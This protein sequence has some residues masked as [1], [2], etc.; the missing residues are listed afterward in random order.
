MR[1]FHLAR[2]I[3]GLLGSSY[4]PALR[5]T[6]SFVI[7]AMDA[8]MAGEYV[9]EIV[10]QPDG[11][12]LLAGKF[13]SVLGAKRSNIARLNAD[14]SLDQGFDPNVDGVV[15]SLLVL[16]D[17]QILLGG[18]FKSLQ[19]NGTTKSVPRRNIAKLQAD[20]TVDEKFTLRADSI[21]STMAQQKD[22]KIMLGGYF[23]S[24]QSSGSEVEVPQENLARV[25]VVGNID[26]TFKLNADLMM[27]SIIV[28]RDGSILLGGALGSL[29]SSG[30]AKPS[31]HQG[32]ARLKADGTIDETFSPG[33]NSDVN[34]VLE[35]PD[36]KILLVGDF[37][38][39]RP[40]GKQVEVPR[41]HV[42][43][44]TQDGSLDASFDPNPDDFV[45]SVAFLRDGT[46][47]LGGQFG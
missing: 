46:I 20:G 44:L 24:L 31:A 9:S 21:V 2:F 43:R 26:G 42:A 35:Q 32:I 16:A 19:P 45:R 1:R 12:V 27:R 7:D 40:N 33:A 25:D 8:G 11:K 36:G 6:E 5:A 18:S 34:A 47:L 22:G 23:M 28:Q 41:L 29:T 10:V 39:V 37:T 15:F 13:T 14:G 3:V 38:K 4:S 30:S 17:G